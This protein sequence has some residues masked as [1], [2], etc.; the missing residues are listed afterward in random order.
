MASISL[1]ADEFGGADEESWLGA[2]EKALKGA[3]FERL[4]TRTGD[5]IVIEPLYRGSRDAIVEGGHAPAMPWT[6]LQRVDHP[7]AGKANAL[8]LEDLADGAAGLDIVGRGAA[9]AFGFGVEGLDKT[10]TFT[11]LFDGV[12]LDAAAL[13]LNAGASLGAAKAL[14]AYLKSREVDP[15]AVTVSFGLDPFG[16]VANTGKAGDIDAAARLAAALKGD[17]FKG[18]FL[19]A[20][21]RAFNAAGAS[22]AQELAAILAAAVSYLRALEAAGVTLEDAATMVEA[23]VAVDA[24]Q[25]LGIAKIRAL[26]RLWRR[27]LTA[28]GIAPSPLAIHA[29]TAWR[30]MTRRDPWV[31]ML[32]T[33]IAGFAAGVGGAD[34]LTVLPFTA[35]LGLPDAFARRVA[36]NT[37]L[38]LIEESNLYRVADPAAGSGFVETMTDDLAKAAWALFQ[39]IEEA[40]GLAATLGAGLLQGKIAEVRA[41]RDRDIA[42]RKAAIT[43][44]SE[45]PNISEAPVEVLDI[46]PFD[47]ATPAEGALPPSRL[48]EPFEHLRDTADAAAAKAGGRVTVFLATLGKV[49]DFTARATF[50]KNFFEAGGIEAIIGD[51]F[52][53]AAAAAE[54]F[55]ASG[56]TIACLCS[57]DALYETLAEETARALKA[58]GARHLSLAGRPGETEA[59]LRAAGVDDFAYMG[60][61]VLDF[62]TRAQAIALAATPAAN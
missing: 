18:P 40:G 15:A 6:A 61:D 52:T 31:N 9:N 38:I 49:A 29:E 43:G 60:C 4:R 12:L 10:E 33:T 21:G 56:A 7:D 28:C 27:V 22:E 5:G 44:T 16:A 50:A 55:T 58:A 53:D 54:A 2:V 51:G 17:G 59:A 42:K 45:F 13:R 37:Q 30:M 8:A 62:L 34:S 47:D 36:R 32:R 41:A 25:F 26:R 24:N 14:A 39:E 20:D 46:A 1:L 11:A 3:S 19:A 23:V 48:A 57:S 35:A